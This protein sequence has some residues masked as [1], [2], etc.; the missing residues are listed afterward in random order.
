MFVLDSPQTM[1]LSIN[2]GEWISPLYPI[3]SQDLVMSCPLEGNPPASYQWYFEK[4]LGDGRLDDAMLIQPN[5]NL[6]ITLLNNNRTLFIEFEEEHNGHYICSAKNSLGNMNHTIF[7]PLE[8]QS[9][10]I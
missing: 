3:Y 6:N 9:E 10:W 8:V 1:Q 5:N 7:P 4:S 2:N